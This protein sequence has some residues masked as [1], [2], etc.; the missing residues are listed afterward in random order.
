MLNDDFI[1][2]ILVLILNI[3][4]FV[5]G[6]IIGKQNSSQRLSEAPGSF[7]KQQK[8]TTNTQRTNIEIDNKKFVGDIKTDTL[9]KKYDSLGETKTSSENISGAINKLKNLKEV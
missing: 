8:N 5:V 2:L 6:Y 1:K 7:F 3:N 4:T 9:E